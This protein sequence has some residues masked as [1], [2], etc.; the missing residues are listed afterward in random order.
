MDANYYV[1]LA[2]FRLR[3]LIRELPCLFQHHAW[4]DWGYDAEGGFAAQV[5]ACE[6]CGRLQVRTFR[7]IHGN[8]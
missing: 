8:D 1:R 4:G 7:V 3:T 5:R 2:H 6:C